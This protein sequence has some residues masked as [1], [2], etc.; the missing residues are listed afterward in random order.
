M[1]SIPQITHRNGAFSYTDAEGTEPRNAKSQFLFF[2]RDDDQIGHQIITLV[3][4]WYGQRALLHTFH[5]IFWE[6]RVSGSAAEEALGQTLVASWT[7][8]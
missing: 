1:N 2:V 5:R 6:N 4:G 8:R 3:L 7:I